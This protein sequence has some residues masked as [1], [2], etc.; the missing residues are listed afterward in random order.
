[1]F[2]LIL[3]RYDLLMNYNVVILK[4]SN[5]FS[6]K[7]QKKPRIFILIL[8]HFRVTPTPARL[9]PGE[10]IGRGRSPLP[11]KLMCYDNVNSWVINSDDFRNNLHF[12]FHIKNDNKPNF[13][14]LLKGAFW[15]EKGGGR[16]GVK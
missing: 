15:E 8:F 12:S 3:F 16:E 6:S 4:L 13:L 2:I 10:G 5:E 14:T 7:F 1:M 11:Q 9:P